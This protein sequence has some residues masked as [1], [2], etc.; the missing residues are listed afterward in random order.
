V[1][2]LRRKRPDLPRPYRVWGY[3][4]VPLVFLV[5]SL[6]MVANA[7]WTEPWKT[8]VT[9]LIILAGVPLFYLWKRLARG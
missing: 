4:W 2:V 7:L 9:L 3:P 1:F 6:G 8:G 5:V